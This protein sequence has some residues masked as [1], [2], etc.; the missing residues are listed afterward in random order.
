MTEAIVYG[1]LL[2][3]TC[4]AVA[5]LYYLFRARS[6]E[7]RLAML[8]AVAELSQRIAQLENAVHANATAP[9][10]RKLDAMQQKLRE[11]DGRLATTS[12]NAVRPT[13]RPAEPVPTD[14]AEAVRAAL[15]ARGFT[16]ITI[17][18]KSELEG[19][20]L[21][22]KVEAVRNGSLQKGSVFVADGSV[23]EA[24]LSPIFEMFP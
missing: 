21:E 8:E 10:E 20:T 16:R 18:T 7:H 11:I 15:S 14:P 6:I 23:G 24:R 5:L 13:G 17:V 22:F 12:S 3:A 19:G 2:I 4:L 9:V 1:L